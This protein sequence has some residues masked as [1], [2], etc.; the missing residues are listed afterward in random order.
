MTRKEEI[1][2]YANS[3]KGKGVKNEKIKEV[4]RLAIIDG[5]TW[6]DAYPKW[7]PSDEQITWLYRAADNASKDSRMKQVL[8]ELLS[9][10]KK[11]REK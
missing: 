3:L 9:D 1:L 10:L 4:V 6:A 7:K 2:N 5:A 8:N 11:L